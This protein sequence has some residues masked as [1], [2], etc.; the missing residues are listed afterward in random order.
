MGAAGAAG[1]LTAT[2]KWDTKIAS[3]EKQGGAKAALAAAYAERGYAR[4]MDD[5]ASPRV[6]YRMALRDFR[7]ALALDPANQKAKKNKVLIEDIYKS[8]GRPIPAE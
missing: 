1:A 7:R 8:M 5:A 4:M 2:P 6:K 3:L